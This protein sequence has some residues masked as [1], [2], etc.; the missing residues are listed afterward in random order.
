MSRAN[1]MGTPNDKMTLRD[2]YDEMWKLDTQYNEEETIGTTHEQ[3][4]NKMERKTEEDWE[5]WDEN[6]TQ[7]KNERTGVYAQV[8]EEYTREEYEQWKQSIRQPERPIQTENAEL[9]EW[10]RVMFEPVSYTHLD[11]YKRQK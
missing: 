6:C 2:I 9:R 1:A 4:D 8:T 11:V 3:D 5:K 7:M 10:I